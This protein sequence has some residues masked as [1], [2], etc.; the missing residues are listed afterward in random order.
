MVHTHQI[1]QDTRIIVTQG[2]TLTATVD[3]LNADGTA[4][5]PE[6][7]D[8]VT[9]TMRG[10]GGVF[11]KAVDMT[12]MI[13]R[14]TAAETGAMAVGTYLYTIKLTTAAGEGSTFIRGRFQIQR[15]A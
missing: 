9:F 14:L 7:G 1:G 13:L 3:L 2:D 5:E 10:R 6:Q 12:D 4:Y 11:T 8:A 15:G